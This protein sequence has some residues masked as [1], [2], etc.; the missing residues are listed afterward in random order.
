MS[1]EKESKGKRKQGKEEPEKGERNART[2]RT[3]R[4]QDGRVLDD[5]KFGNRGK[6]RKQVGGSISIMGGLFRF[7]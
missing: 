3:A 4:A 1:N 7:S 6:L 2:V 5:S